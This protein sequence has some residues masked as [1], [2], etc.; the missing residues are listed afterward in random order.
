MDK[1]ILQ[2]SNMP[3]Y[4]KQARKFIYIDGTFYPIA[5]EDWGR[6]NYYIHYRFKLYLQL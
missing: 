1:A 3:V 2:Y 5:R 6:F 4:E